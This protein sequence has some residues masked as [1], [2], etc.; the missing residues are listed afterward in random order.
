MFKLSEKEIVSEEKKIFFKSW[1]KSPIQLGT[2]SPMSQ[3]LAKKT[4]Q[5]FGDN[6]DG[7]II[8][9]G[10]GSGR[11]TRELIRKGI[12]EDFAAIELDEKLF[13][14]LKK[15]IN[16]PY[17]YHEN[18]SNLRNFL[19]SEWICNIKKIFSVIPFMYLPKDERD[20]IFNELLYCLADDGMIIH[21]TYSPISPFVHRQD[22]VQKCVLKL[23][24][25]LP[26]AFIWTFSKAVT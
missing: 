12:T 2:F 6:M 9:V 16:I 3:K 13:N 17:L 26:P 19:P 5:L 18:A 7:P 25:N 23:W 4:V 10:A 22:L 1:I 24:K 8:E 11:L 14:F 21:V 20:T 15:T